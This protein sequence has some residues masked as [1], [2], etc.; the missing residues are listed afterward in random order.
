MAQ[1]QL[2]DT[3]VAAFVFS[4]IK[5]LYRDAFDQCRLF[6][7]LRPARLLKITDPVNLQPVVGG[8]SQKLLG[9]FQ[10]TEMVRLAMAGS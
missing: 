9:E 1:P 3:Q 2:V 4:H 7:T 8:R 6:G 10:G 5:G